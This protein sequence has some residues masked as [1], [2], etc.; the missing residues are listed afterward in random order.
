MRKLSLL[1]AIT[2]AV[3]GVT[4]PA[5]AADPPSQVVIVDDAMFQSG[6]LTAACGTPVFITVAGV[7]HI[8]LR[9]DR[10]G[11]LVEHD[12]FGNHSITFSAP[13]TG[14]SAS[15]KFGPSE[16]VYPEGVFIGAQ[17]IV[18]LTGIHAD[19][20]GA[21]AEAGRTVLEGVVVGVSPDGV[22]FVDF[23][24]P[25]LFEQGNQ[26]SGE[27]SLANLCAALTA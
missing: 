9:I 11:V 15:Y 10:D 7:V 3:T 21:P 20:P 25:T 19:Y 13:A 12:A 26:L 6:F 14:G 16:Y 18:T 8:T 4:S 27:E 2:A 1:A 22:P 23:T 17:S 24:G 5:V